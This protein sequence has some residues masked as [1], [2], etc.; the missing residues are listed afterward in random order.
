[1]KTEYKRLIKFRRLYFYTS[2]CSSLYERNK[3]VLQRKERDKMLREMYLV[4]INGTRKA[5]ES[6]LG[7]VDPDRRKDFLEGKEVK[8]STGE[9][10]QYIG[11]RTVA[12]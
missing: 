12:W 4:T 8:T 7:I 2:F 3:Y 6:I 5:L 9:T 10:V 11:T 1:M